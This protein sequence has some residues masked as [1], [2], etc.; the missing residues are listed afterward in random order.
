M[1]QLALAWFA[2]DPLKSGLIAGIVFF[3]GL[4]GVQT[5][6]LGWVQSTVERLEKQIATLTAQ[7]EAERARAQAERE[8]QIAENQA[9]QAQWKAKL[10]EANAT[11]QRNV[12]A[13]EARAAALARDNAQL[14]QFAEAFANGPSG[15]AGDSIASC[16]ARAQ[17]LAE[18]FA[19]ADRVAGEMAGEADRR[20]EQVELCLDAWPRSVKRAAVHLDDSVGRLAESEGD[21]V[22]VD[23]AV[24]GREF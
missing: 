8:A 4:A 14:R 23:L 5:V 24:L 6:R 11:A 12:R 3:T 7:Y 9:M 19:E 18:L 13:A 1:I 22:A 2:K 15:A 17:T 16:R 21:R 10:E 20:A